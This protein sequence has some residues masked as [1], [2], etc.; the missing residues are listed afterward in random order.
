MS[1]L[2]SLAEWPGAIEKLFLTKSFSFTGR[3][4]LRLWRASARQWEVVVVDDRFPVRPQSGGLP[5]Y[6]R[7]NG[8]ELWVRGKRGEY[9]R[10]VFKFMEI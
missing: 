4:R 7:P 5:L 3:Y 10:C 2:A 9:M 8:R 1:A 6:A